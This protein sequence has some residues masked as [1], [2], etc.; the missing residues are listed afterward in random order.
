M[1]L[2]SDAILKTAHHLAVISNEA[3]TGSEENW[4]GTLN[5]LMAMNTEISY[6]ELILRALLDANRAEGGL[7]PAPTDSQLQ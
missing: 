1:K 6:M 3:Q 5:A 7:P 2:A 4:A